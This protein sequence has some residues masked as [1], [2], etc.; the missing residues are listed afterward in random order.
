[1]SVPG[2][3]PG[4]QLEALLRGIEERVKHTPECRMTS[5]A[6]I[7][8]RAA[9]VRAEQARAV[10]RML[11]VVYQQAPGDTYSKAQDHDLVWAAALRAGEEHQ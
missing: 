7:C 1:M 8:D 4:P 5:T 6:C 11:E 9:R 10:E 2:T 3:G